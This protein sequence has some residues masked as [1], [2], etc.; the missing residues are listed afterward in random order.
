MWNMEPKQADKSVVRLVLEDGKE[1]RADRKG[2]SEASAFFA[3]LLNIDMKENRE[4]I[5]RLEH[6]TETVMRDVLD[7]IRS[8][9]V[10]ILTLENAKDLIEAADFL[11]IPSL[12]TVAGNFMHQNCK[13]C[14]ANCISTYYYAEKYQIECL[15][16][17]SMKFIFLNFLTVAESQEFLSLES[18]QVEQ[19]LCS[20][21]I[22]VIS[23]DDVFKVILQWIEHSKS[24]RKRKFKEL[25]R[26]VRWTFISRDYLQSDVVTNELVKE[27]SNWLISDD[28]P[29]LPRK[30]CD[31]H[32][33][34]F[35]GRETL[36]YQPDEDKWYH[37]ADAP[38]YRHRQYHMTPC[39]QKL[40]VFP[41]YPATHSV[42]GEFYDPSLNRWAE[43]GFTYHSQEDR[44][45]V[46]VVEGE[47]F[48]VSYSGTKL[49]IWKYNMKSSSWQMVYCTRC[50][51]MGM[52]WFGYGHCAVAMENY[53]YICGGYIYQYSSGQVIMKTTARF[54]TATNEFELL[55]EM[56]I[57][58]SHACG[59]AAHG[60]IFIAGGK[61][62]DRCLNTNT[63]ETSCEVYNIETNEWQ[64]I[65]SLNA[66]RYDASMVCFKGT[67]YVVGGVHSG[68][69]NY[70]GCSLALTV[71][72]YDF[73]NNEWKQ[74][75]EIPIGTVLSRK[76]KKIV[77]ACTL[78]IS[79]EVLRKPIE[80]G[81]LASIKRAF[82][83]R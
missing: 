21:E 38:L 79:Q 16:V 75:T 76:S 2:L 57:E 39:Q 71:E 1:I 36:C 77:R 15:V 41:T 70:D 24:E 47:I 8:G 40:Y 52:G 13:L 83:Q 81:R 43:L 22:A 10:N 67:L 60:K 27:N 28:R 82:K 69:Y 20:D 35:T 49:C 50:R 48:S 61:T 12:K 25:F 23:E 72:S 53:L 14:A 18:K 9:D 34:V 3:S 68:S 74:T 54:N 6:I 64:L 73:E 29:Q 59:C 17:K 11:V 44:S 62:G 30:W 63:F 56:K 26:H 58:R 51:R 32:L 4:G 46:A 31:T 66:P 7:F 65:A 19:W 42:A 33:V 5:I 37:L 80:M 55:S 45:A 78:N